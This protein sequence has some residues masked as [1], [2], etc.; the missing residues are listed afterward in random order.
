MA[1]KY[2][3][4]LLGLSCRRIC[5]GKRKIS[6]SAAFAGQL[7]GAMEIEKRIWLVGFL[8]HDPGFF[9]D[10]EA[11]VEPGPN[12]FAAEKVLTMSPA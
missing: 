5:H 3:L 2:S 8:N 7:G 4:L 11:R 1:I 6:V 12:S 9:D 10:N